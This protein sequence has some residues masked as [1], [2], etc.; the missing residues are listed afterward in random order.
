[1]VSSSNASWSMTRRLTATLTLLVGALWIAG[2]T[3]AAWSI[4]HEIDEVFD[5]AL[6][7]TAQRILPLAA[8]DL[9]E[10][11]ET[12]ESQ[13]LPGSAGDD[14]HVEYLH[15]QVRDSVGRVLLRSHDAPAAP[16]PA[17][18]TRGFYDDGER[19]YFTQLSQSGDLAVQVAELPEERREA[20]LAV[21]VGLLLPLLGLLPLAAIAIRATVTRTTR[22]MHE[23]RR[24]IGNRD[25]SN[26][27]P[28][29]AHSL[30][31]ELAPI[32]WDMNRLLERLKTAL[33][34]ERGFAANSA[35]ELRNPIAAARAQA[36]IIAQSANDEVDQKRARNLVVTLTGLGRKIETML[37]LARADSGLGLSR[38]AT[39]L[40]AVTRLLAD[41]Y[42]R[43][44]QHNGRIVLKDASGGRTMV[45]IDPDAL[46][47]AIQNLLDN[48]LKYDTITGQIVIT[49]EAG[50]V[51]SV[52][53]EG[54]TVSEAELAKLRERF[55]RGR[56]HAS[57]GTG[58]G[59]YIVDTIMRQAGGQLDLYSPARGCTSG[60]EA[61]LHF[62]KPEAASP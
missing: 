57:D 60:F 36:E 54:P 61:V 29:D 41:E 48:A 38:E 53:N 18:L 49:L 16:F 6:Q 31:S 27:S 17:P 5:S 28:L 40:A 8:D 22:P 52:T 4:R 26:L 10:R 39:D 14:G 34:A 20:A 13:P 37:Q 30:P 44:P 43:K 35:H 19:R 45:A 21:W 2:V 46:G 3:F 42:A 58:L 1:M 25:G 15:Y 23:V 55:A 12:S 50:P 32:V 33:E 7:E 59:L 56:N 51:L 62:A 47:I 11:P 9:H 24:E